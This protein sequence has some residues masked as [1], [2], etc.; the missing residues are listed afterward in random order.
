MRTRRLWLATFAVLSGLTLAFVGGMYWSQHSPSASD[1]MPADDDPIA[2]LYRVPVDQWPAP[3]VDEGIDWQPLGPLPE[4]PAGRDWTPL[5]HLGRQLFFDPRMSSSG[6]IACASCH[7]PEHGWTDGRQ[8][9][10]G[11]LRAPGTR[12]TQSLINAAFMDRL[13]RDGRAGSLEAQVSIPLASDIEMHHTPAGAVQRIAARESYATQ[14]EAAFGDPEVT[15]PRIVS[16]IADFER[17]LISRSSRFDAFIEGKHDALS[18]QE[19]RGLHWFR[20]QG[21]C[22][23]CHSGPLF[24][25]Q[26]FHNLGLN[27][28]GR[29]LQDLGRYNV[30]GKPEDVGT[31]RT[32]PLRDVAFT[33]PYMHN[34]MIPRL[35]N[36]LLFYNKGGA[37]PK[38]GEKHADDPLFPKTSPL[39][40]PLDLSAAQ[41]D[42]MEAFLHAIS[43]RQ[44]RLSMRFVADLREQAEQDREA[45]AHD[46]DSEIRR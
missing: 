41:I 7:D 6:Q 3:T 11:H 35:R 40:Q 36:V 31:F 20:T 9:P 46:A 25:D 23:N 42:D 27:F 19:I 18:D 16:A 37:H 30:T 29:P 28:Y 38:R 43:T 26:Q 24:T 34:G 32:S 21:R 39:L 1:P 8:L 4:P 45:G 22:M 12:N 33:A 2:A 44:N 17:R 15:Y 14:F 5:T 10:F 13:F